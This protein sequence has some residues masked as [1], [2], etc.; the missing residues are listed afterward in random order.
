MKPLRYLPVWVVIRLC[1]DESNIVNYWNIIEKELELDMDVI[2]DLKSEADEIYIHNSWLTYG[3]QFHRLREFGIQIK[4][5]DLLDENILAM[6]QMRTI[7]DL[8]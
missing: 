1:T 8:M 6:D 7:C 4:E 3:E 5:I 2:D